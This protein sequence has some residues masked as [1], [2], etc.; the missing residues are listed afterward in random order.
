[1]RFMK[2]RLFL[3]MTGV[4]LSACEGDEIVP[5]GGRKAIRLTA[6]IEGMRTRLSG[7]TWE[8]GDA[9][10]VYMKR[11]GASLDSSAPEQNVKYSYNAETGVFEPK[12]E[13][14]TIYFPFTGDRVD[15]IGYYPYRD[16]VNDFTLPI[17]LS[18]Q[19]KQSALD[20]MYADNVKDVN[21]EQANVRMI[22]SHK[23]SKIMIQVKHYRGIELEDLSVIITSVPV[24]GSF[25]LKSGNLTVDPATSDVACCVNKDCTLAEAILMPGTDL[26]GSEL[27]FVTGEGSEA[28]K[29]DLDTLFTTGSLSP[30]T[31]YTFAATLFTDEVKVVT[32]STGIIPWN[33]LDSVTFTANRTTDAPPVIKGSMSDPYTVAQ[34]ISNQDKQDVWAIG[35]IVGAFDKS[36][37]KFVTDTTG[38]V[39]TNIALSDNRGETDVTRMLPVNFTSA[40]L[41]NA[42]NI[43]DNPLNINRLV[44]IRGDLEAYYSVPGMR[45]T[46]DYLFLE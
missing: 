31:Q 11:T 27:W 37:N 17:D 20:L 5:A 38:Q 39:K 28:Y 15:F 44:M 7:S 45:N 21:E 25:D 26:S 32:D 30:S 13:K 19:S 33:S 3:L 42:L 36:I 6:E 12:D 2:W 18:V 41:K 35:Y 16:P 14:G 24:T 40:S 22:F 4:L 43:C 8:K 34:A 1:M 29:V 10:G 9:I 23:L 46:T